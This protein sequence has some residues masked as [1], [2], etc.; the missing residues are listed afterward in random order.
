MNSLSQGGLPVDVAETVA[1]FASARL[2][3]RERQR[4]AR[5]RPEPARRLKR[6]LRARSSPAARARSAPGGGRSDAA[7]TRELHARRRR[8]RP[9]PP[10]RVR[11][12]VRLPAARRAA[13]HLP[14]R[15]RLPAGDRADDRAAFPFSLLGL[16]HV[17]NRIEQLRPIR[18]D[19]RPRPARARRRPA[20]ARRGHAVRHG[21]RGD[22]R[23]RGRLARRQHLPAPRAQRRGG[24]P[25]RRRRAAG[26]RPRCGACPD[27]IGRRY[28]PSRATATR[29]TCTRSARAAFGQPG[30]IAH[31]MWRRRA[32]SPRSRARC[33]TPTRSTCGSSCRCGSRAGSCSRAA[34][35][36]SRCTTPVRPAAPDRQ[37]RLTPNVN[38]LGGGG[39][40]P[41]RPTPS[42]RG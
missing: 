9:R 33:P 32:A 15:A 1:W 13:G 5:L 10:G 18:A 30:A 14:A 39:E 21:G 34:R 27:D 19:E 4:R 40:T 37:H 12:R 23:R 3:R 38:C 36:R 25:A 20:A 17:A 11:P 26:R 8:D 24:G 28:A 29:S 7:R 6:D 35:A 31:G 2:G 22:G 42:C 41:G 16:V